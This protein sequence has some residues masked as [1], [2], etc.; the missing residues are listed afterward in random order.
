MI[1]PAHN[2]GRYIGK[3]IESIR[4][5]SCSDLEIIVVDDGST[6]HTYQICEKLAEADDRIKLIHIE[7]SGVCAARRRGLELAAS[8]V[9]AFADADDWIAPDMLEKMYDEMRR[10]NADI[11]IAGYTETADNGS[12]MLRLNRISAGVYS[13]EIL[14]EQIWDKMLCCEEF[15]D[16]GM[17]PYLWNK[18]FRRNVIEPYIR[19]VN[20]HIFMGEDVVCLIPAILQSATVSILD[21]GSYHYCIHHGAA[22]KSYRKD[23]IAN[24]KEQYHDLKKFCSPH[25]Y[26]ECVLPQIERYIIHHML[27]RDY[28]YV[29]QQLVRLDVS[30]FENIHQGSRLLLYGAGTLGQAVYRA[31]RQSDRYELVGWCD[32]S[33]EKCSLNDVISVEE[34]VTRNF[35]FIVIAVFSMRL[36]REIKNQL[37]LQG[38]AEQKISWLDTESLMQ[39]MEK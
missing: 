36:A 38:V 27:V 8:S 21:D 32:R 37:R 22:M 16:M 29:E 6:D 23:E 30:V 15:F 12:E 18:L 14:K 35:D 25:A 26:Y 13:G 7:H 33:A 17:Q 1:V 31:W 24:I 39:L 10:V 11:V 3:C 28:A 5:Q 34:A 9:I 4:R 19:A 20:T 2:A